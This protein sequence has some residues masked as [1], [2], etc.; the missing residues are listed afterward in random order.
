MSWENGSGRVGETGAGCGYY[1]TARVPVLHQTRLLSC[2][3]IVF[4]CLHRLPS[5]FNTPF[6][7]CPSL[8]VNL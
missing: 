2:N 4:I 1:E 7:S 3:I 8:S 6:V 5:W